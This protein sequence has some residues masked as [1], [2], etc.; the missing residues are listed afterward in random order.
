MT[1]DF[2]GKHIRESSGNKL[3]DIVTALDVCR[4]RHRGQQVPANTVI[5]MSNLE[6]T[7][8]EASAAVGYDPRCCASS[9]AY[10][11]VN[12]SQMGIIT[13]TS[14]TRFTYAL[15]GSGKVSHFVANP[16]LLGGFPENVE[17]FKARDLEN[18][19]VYH[20]SKFPQTRGFTVHEGSGYS[21]AASVQRDGSTF[22]EFEMIWIPSSA[23]NVGERFYARRSDLTAARIESW[24]KCGDQIQ[25]L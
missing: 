24:I 16:G 12:M 20:K 2:A 6:M 9:A 18:I 25:Q 15:D 22:D 23:D 5:F 13:A 10:L 21:V 17:L 14:N 11:A 19:R 7:F 3:D 1:G 8:F 4:T